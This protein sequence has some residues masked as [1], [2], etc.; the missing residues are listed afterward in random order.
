MTDEQQALERRIAELDFQVRI[1]EREAA[2]S[3]SELAK[4]MGQAVRLFMPAMSQAYCRIADEDA[5]ERIQTILSGQE[6]GPDTVDEIAEVVMATGREVQ[7]P[8]AEEE[9]ADLD[10]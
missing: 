1:R 5:M 10:T 4:L 2:R 9:E 7:E 3:R 6:W 8:Q